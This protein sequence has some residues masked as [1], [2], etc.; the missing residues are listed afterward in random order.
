VKKVDPHVL[1]SSAGVIKNTSQL[2]L[3]CI[4]KKERLNFV[5][6]IIF[7]ATPV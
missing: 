7:F 6:L 3:H 4:R 1:L 5:G 2:T